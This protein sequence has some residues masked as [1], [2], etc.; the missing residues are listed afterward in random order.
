M[1]ATEQIGRYK[2]LE[3]IGRGA[4]G[5]VYRASDPA[6][7]RTI[8]VKTIRLGSSSDAER[9]A[10]LDRLRREAQSAGRLSH[11][12]IVTVYDLV[13]SGDTVY[14]CMELVEGSSLEDLMAAGK[15]FTRADV[16]EV[17]RHTASAL[18]YA[19]S[20]GVVHR[21]IKPGNI[22]LREKAG[23]KITDFGIAKLLAEEAT[24][25]ASGQLLGTPNYMSPEQMQSKPLDGKSDQFSLAVVAY[26]LL[27]GEKP[28]SGYSIPAIAYKVCNEAPPPATGMNRSLAPAVNAVF[29]RALAK[30]AAARYLNVE[31]F[32][33]AL[34]RALAAAPDW[35]P[36]VRGKVASE[37]TIAADE[38][39]NASNAA[40]ASVASE[41][42]PVVE[43]P[44]LLTQA[45]KVPLRERTPVVVLASGLAAFAAMGVIFWAASQ[46]ERGESPVPKK[47]EAQV[48]VPKSPEPR[49]EKPSPAEQTP[50]EPA[51]NNAQ[52]QSSPVTVT[53]PVVPRPP[54]ATDFEVR[55]EPS[56]A[57][58][59]IDGNPSLSCVTP[60]KLTLS[61]RRHTF[62]FTMADHRAALYLIDVP[63][64]SSLDVKLER[65][66][67]RVMVKSDPPGATIFVDGKQWP[68]QTPTILSLPVGRHKLQVTKEGLLADESEVDVRDGAVSELE[69]NWKK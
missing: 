48:T 15:S 31:E 54:A 21:D 63:E 59:E 40:A 67:G 34:E 61:S 50:A 25:V 23:V 30:K 62:R 5:V 27:T 26:E 1:S 33:S 41:Q 66:A 37:V 12:N 11:P 9:G 51:A 65:Q 56:G 68:S 43:P 36:Q 17:L 6:I 44:L 39:V 49:P 58:V 20:H 64:R 55:S 38:P 35:I 3:E 52:T 24:L 16:L 69:V 22:L 32:V 8:A 46:Q 29:A 10:L 60:C 57:T 28:F 4:M 2:I 7:G 18:D 14:V 19:H 13:E 45:R 42:V 53:A 47:A